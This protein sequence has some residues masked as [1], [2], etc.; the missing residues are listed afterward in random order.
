MRA[1]TQRK[2]N[3]RLKKISESKKTNCEASLAE[4]SLEQLSVT[5]KQLTYKFDSLNYFWAFCYIVCFVL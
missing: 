5:L 2:I 4:Q 3:K 1:S